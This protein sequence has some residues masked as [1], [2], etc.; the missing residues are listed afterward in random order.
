MTRHISTLILALFV[1]IVLF[2]INV[3]AEERFT[4]NNDGT[5]TDHQ[6]SLMWAKTDNFGDINWHQ[7]NKWIRYTFPYSLPVLYENW[8]LPTLKELKSLYVKSDD[9]SGYESECGQLLKIT[10]EIHLTCGFVWSSDR[11]SITA[12]VFN[13]KR[14]IYYSDRLVH[15]RG[16]RALA[17]RDLQ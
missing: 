16:Y 3:Y 6:L 2:C 8:R 1:F 4:E 15:K 10:P 5:L 11:Q 7:A 17:V 14:G 12:H 9:Y 13:F